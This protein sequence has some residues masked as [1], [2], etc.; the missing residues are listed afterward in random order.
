VIAAPYELS[1]FSLS[2]WLRK[3]TN[4]ASKYAP[5]ATSVGGIIEGNGSLVTKAGRIL[6]A[7]QSWA[8]GGAINTPPVTPGSVPVPGPVVVPVGSGNRYTSGGLSNQY[9]LIGGAALLA[10]LV[11]R[12]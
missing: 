7:T 2:R 3:A 6:N 11:L 9:L 10:I 5:L 4:T 1:G 8:N 12:R